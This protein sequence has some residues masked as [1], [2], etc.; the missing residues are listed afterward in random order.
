M[1]SAAATLGGIFVVALPTLVFV[2]PAPIDVICDRPEEWYRCPSSQELMVVDGRL[3]PCWDG[4]RCQGPDATSNVLVR[5][6]CHWNILE[7]GGRCLTTEY[8]GP[9][10]SWYPL[11]GSSVVPPPPSPALTNLQSDS[12]SGPPTDPPPGSAAANTNPLTAFQSPNTPIRTPT[13]EPSSWSLFESLQNFADSFGGP[14]PPGFTWA[15]YRIEASLNAGIYDAQAPAFFDYTPPLLGWK[16]P[17]EGTAY[18]TYGE[19]LPATPNLSTNNSYL[20]YLD[21]PAPR[22]FDLPQ[23]PP[24]TGFAAGA[25]E[26]QNAL[27]QERWYQN[28]TRAA[29]YVSD[30]AS[31]V[32]QNMTAENY[33]NTVRNI[34]CSAPLV[35][36]CDN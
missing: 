26:L 12:P 17:E 34:R 14:P 7:Q 36:R 28:L 5:G 8:Q 4:E 25:N 22:F 9:D 29:S 10:N 13:P 31:Y 33:R 27:Q 6:I 16:T 15:D 19:F 24:A 2:Q 21:A 1:R 30:T 11:A 3:I 35:F 23:A 18:Y 20:S 32:W